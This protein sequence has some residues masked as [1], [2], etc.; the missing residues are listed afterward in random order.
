MSKFNCISSL[1]RNIRRWIGKHAPLQ[2][3]HRGS[4]SPSPTSKL[5]DQLTPNCNALTQARHFINTAVKDL[6]T[7]LSCGN[8]QINPP[9]KLQKLPRTM[10]WRESSVS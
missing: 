8:I 4:L 10:T 1:T 3:T 6:P 2:G 7:V 9:S 5:T